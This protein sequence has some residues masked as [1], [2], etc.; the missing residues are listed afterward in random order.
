MLTA[1]TRKG[2]SIT[3]ARLSKQDIT[4]LRQTESFV[5][6]ACKSEV[7]IKAG[8]IITPHF[9]HVSEAECPERTG[10]EG[11][12]HYQGKLLLYEWFKRQGINVLLEHYLSDIQQRPDLLIQI[13]NRKIAIEFQC[14]KVNSQTIYQRNIGYQRANI[15][16]I[17]I[18]GANLFK[19]KSTHHIQLNRFLTS[20]IHQFSRTHPTTLFFFCPEKQ[21]FSFV[22]DIIFT[23]NHKALAKQTFTPMYDISFNH[24]FLKKTFSKSELFT[25]WN[26]ELKSF[27]LGKR[28]NFGQERAW[29][30]WLYEKG[31]HIDHLPTYIYLPIRSQYKMNVPLWIWQSRVLLDFLPRVSQHKIFHLNEVERFLQ[32]FIKKKV[33]EQL[34]RASHNPIEEYLSVLCEFSLLKQLDD[35]TFVQQQSLTF[36][37]QI[38]EALDGDT[39]LLFR[40]MYNEGNK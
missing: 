26:N 36:Y 14:A 34:I 23:T 13:K 39:E 33:D 29:R 21:Q 2:K 8:N 28:P 18:L 27:R 22:Q 3:L 24:F 19:R 37:K 25:L 11:E 17:W 31:L 4:Q 10:G 38:E 12:Y 1:T 9:A 16:P 6:P 15:I 5:C 35:V 20:F 32:R 40:F 30:T 7:I